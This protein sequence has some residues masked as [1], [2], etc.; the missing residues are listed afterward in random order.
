MREESEERDILLDS[1]GHCKLQSCVFP[2]H[3]VIP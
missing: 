1:E 2:I 3:P